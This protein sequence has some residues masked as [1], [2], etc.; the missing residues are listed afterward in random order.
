MN[1]PT[2][3]VI[4]P[5]YNSEEHLCGCIDSLINQTISGIEIILI[6]DGSTDRSGEI[7]DEYASRDAHVRVIH[8]ENGG[9]SS[10]RNAGLDAACGE[11]I[12]FVDSDDTVISDMYEYMLG[13]AETHGAELVQCAM[14]FDTKDE[15]RVILSPDGNIVADGIGRLDGRFFAHFSGSSC[16]KIYKRELVSNVRFD[17]ELTIGEDMRFNLDA[18]VRAQR[19]VLATKP[20]Y[21]YAQRGDSACNAAP[22]RERLTSYGRMLRGAMA[23]FSALPQ[24]IEFLRAET[25]KNA[26]DVCSRAVRSG[27]GEFEDLFEK[28]RSEIVNLKEWIRSCDAFTPKERLKITLLSH[29]P[30]SYKFLIGKLKR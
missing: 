29:F 3:S 8:K 15:S 25:V 22:T 14:F 7:C 17:S 2:L 4:V 18:L 16:C 1:K 11:W 28:S 20:K 6:N 9:V 10:A 21:R 26:L 27:G 23:D 13:V 19:T 12:G 30:L 24:I 5:V